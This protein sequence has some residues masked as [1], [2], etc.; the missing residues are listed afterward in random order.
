LEI[1]KLSYDDIC[2]DLPTSLKKFRDVA[3]C[4]QCLVQFQSAKQLQNHYQS[5][6]N[7]TVLE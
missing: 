6:H 3:H 1:R 5:V 2:K 7:K 4:S